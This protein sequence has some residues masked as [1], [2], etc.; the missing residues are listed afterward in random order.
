MK[1][2]DMFSRVTMGSASAIVVMLGCILVGL[3][4]GAHAG[5]GEEE[6]LKALQRALAAPVDKGEEFSAKAI[7]FDRDGEAGAARADAA[8][9]PAGDV[10]CASVQPDAKTTAVDF[11]IQFKSGSAALSPV[12]ENTLVQIAKVLAL[13]PDRCVLVEG[14]TDAKGNADVN[15][16]L[17]RDRANTVVNY[18]VSKAGIKRSRLIPEGKGST[19]PL[20]NLDPRD[21]KNRRVVFKVVG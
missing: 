12:S 2:S 20:Q 3:S 11:E 6:K 1:G 10:D 18:I 8:K 17:S 16:K 14:H 9:Q 13:T 21:S 7:V 5:A 19:E 15:L 4:S